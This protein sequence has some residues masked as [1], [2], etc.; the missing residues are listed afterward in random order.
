[1]ADE[2]VTDLT[3]ITQAAVGDLLYVVDVSDTTDDAS[4][5]SK[6]IARADLYSLWKA[7][8][9]LSSASFANTENVIPWSSFAIDGGAAVTLSGTPQ[10]DININTTGVYKFSVTLRTNS[11]NRT[12]LLINTYVDTG[13]GYVQD[14]DEIVSDYVSRDADQNTGAVTLVTALALNAGD[15]VEFRGEGDTDGTCVGLDAGTILLIEKVG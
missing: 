15:L 9:N 11:N 2:K 1:M 12:E 7:K 3:A 6:K 13:S 14:T 8:G 4:G 10:S 5:S